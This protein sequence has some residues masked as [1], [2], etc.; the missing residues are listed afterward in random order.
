MVCSAVH[1]AVDNDSVEEVHG[2]RYTIKRRSPRYEF[3]CDLVK[4][5]VDKL[6][7]D[8]LVVVSEEG[9]FYGRDEMVVEGSL[10]NQF[11]YIESIGERKAVDIAHHA[12]YGARCLLLGR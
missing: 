3:V 8:S 9:E 7:S 11:K 2:I 5:T 10:R 1:A 6:S 12:A 4:E